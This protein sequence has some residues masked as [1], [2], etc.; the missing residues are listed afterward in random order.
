M[1]PSGVSL[2]ANLMAMSEKSS[3]DLCS[4]MVKKT[5]ISVTAGIKKSIKKVKK[6]TI[7]HTHVVMDSELRGCS[8]STK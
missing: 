4:R 2:K 6:P 8:P 5:L 3:S 1:V 7:A